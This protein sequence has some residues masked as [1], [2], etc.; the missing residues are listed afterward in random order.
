MDGL[1]PGDKVLLLGDI[2]NIYRNKHFIVK[3]IQHDGFFF[4][5]ERG[6]L[7]KHDLDYIIVNNRELI[8]DL[9]NE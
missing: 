8:E 3:S 2:L 6:I 9:I 7:I 5:D 4:E 1:K